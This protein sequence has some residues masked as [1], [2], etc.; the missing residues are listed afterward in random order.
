MKIGFGIGISYQYPSLIQGVVNP[1]EESNILMW[2]DN[3][4]VL[5]EDNTEISIETE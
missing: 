1:P 4:S 3:T 5:W 2:E